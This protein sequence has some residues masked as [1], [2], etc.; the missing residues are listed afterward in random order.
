MQKKVLPFSLK[1]SAWLISG[2]G[3]LFPGLAARIFFRLYGTPPKRRLRDAHLKARSKAVTRQDR[4]SKYSFDSTALKIDSYTW[5]DGRGRKVLIVHGWADTGLGFPGLTEGLARAG[6]TVVAID[7]PA[8]GTSEG[9][10]TN[11][12]QWIHILDQVLNR[13]QPIYA[14]I[15]HSVGAL[16]SA[17][18]LARKGVHVPRLVLAGAPL[19]AAAFFQD[20]FELFGIR[21]R[22]IAA[23]YRLVET[24]LGDDL[25]TMSLDDCVGRMN[26]ERILMVY[27]SSDQLVREG[28]VAAFLHRH[29][30][31]QAERIE[32][33]G[34][35]RILKDPV[36]I[37]A[38]ISFLDKP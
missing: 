3:S 9:K 26:T 36:V 7:N 31:I 5:G 11:L 8:H 23:V 20:T 16:T 22:V 37:K 4:F 28:D 27:D 34:H 10:R 19:S 6:Y 21:P 18:T 33:A 15:G 14:M 1:A 38:I 24:K 25:R 12:V 2:L 13:E 17:L 32:G 29:P 30:A 35:F